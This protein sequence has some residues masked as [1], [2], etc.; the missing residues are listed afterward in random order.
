MFDLQ[1]LAV[2]QD[3]YLVE[4]RNPITFEVLTHEDG[5]PFTIG[6]LS[7]DTNKSRTGIARLKREAKSI[8]NAKTTE[9]LDTDYYIAKTIAECT[10][11][12]NLVFGK[13][14]MKHS[15]DAMTKLLSNPQYN[16]VK[17][18]VSAAMDNRANFIKS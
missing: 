9:E 6:V 10:T 5:T 16:W 3:E 1:D 13:K 17:D 14:K 8:T 2:S 7:S 4:L 12:C 11:S 18:Q 15:V